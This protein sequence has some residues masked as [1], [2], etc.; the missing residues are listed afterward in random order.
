MTILKNIHVSAAP[1]DE[2]CFVSGIYD[3][4]F[5]KTIIYYRFIPLY[6]IFTICY[7]R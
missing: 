1:R 6:L 7:I 5:I 2:V 4:E 3:L